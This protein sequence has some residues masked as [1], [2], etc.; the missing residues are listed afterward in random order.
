MATS[1]DIDKPMVNSALSDSTKIKN[2]VNKQFW[3]PSDHLTSI[4][5]IMVI[6]ELTYL[7]GN[8]ISHFLEIAKKIQKKYG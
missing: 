5:R 4:S 7:K 2:R 8:V 3:N 6:S 1:S